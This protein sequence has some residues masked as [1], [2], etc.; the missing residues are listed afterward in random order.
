MLARI[1]M[2]DE[3]AV[4]RVTLLERVIQLEENTNVG[5]PIEIFI[6]QRSK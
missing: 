2:A 3:V 4:I 1:D 5:N 6:V